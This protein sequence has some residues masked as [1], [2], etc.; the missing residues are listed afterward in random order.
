[1]V[2]TLRALAEP[3]LFDQTESALAHIWSQRP[4]VPAAIRQQVSIALGE[5]LG[6]IVEHGLDGVDHPVHVEMEIAVSSHQLVI[7]VTDDGDD[8]GIDLD[9][10]AMPDWDAESG[11]GLAM[12]K[13]VLESFTYHRGDDGNHWRLASNPF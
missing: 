3:A 12:A 10:V 9:A 11:R 6:N 5:V 8:P 2:S 7:T 13:A 4:Q 1:M